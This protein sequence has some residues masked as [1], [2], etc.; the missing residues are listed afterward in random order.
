[1]VTRK[2][3][4]REIPMPTWVIQRVEA[5]AINDVWDL[6]KGYEPLFVDRFANDND[7]A[8]SLHE[9]GI[10]IVVYD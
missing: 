10:E 4:I 8:A 5:L 3:K 1:M 6:P 2:Q 7:F 9:G